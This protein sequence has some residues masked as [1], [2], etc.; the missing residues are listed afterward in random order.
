MCVFCFVFLLGGGGLRGGGS[1]WINLVSRF[2]FSSFFEGGREG[3]F[4][5]RGYGA[6]GG[7]GGGGG[8]GIL[9]GLALRFVVVVFRFLLVHFFFF[10]PFLCL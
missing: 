5:G 1:L 9:Q 7:G 8:G 2:D 3:G 4:R 10:F 6:V